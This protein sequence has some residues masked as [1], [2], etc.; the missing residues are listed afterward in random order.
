MPKISAL[1]RITSREQLT[2]NDLIVVND[3]NVTKAISAQILSNRG[4]T[5]YENTSGFEGFNTENDFNWPT[6]EG[7]NYTQTQADSESWMLISLD[8]Q[9][10]HAKDGPYWTDPTPLDHSG[11][12]LFGGANNPIG[13]SSLFDFE[14]DFNSTYPTL[15]SF[16]AY[17]SSANAQLSY[18][19]FSGSTGRI[20]LSGT[21]PGDQLRARFSYNIIPQVS[22]T[23]VETALWYANR[24]TDDKETFSFPLTTSPVF[25][26][27]GSPGQSYLNR[28]EISAWIG[29]SEDVNA[30]TLPAVR[31]NNPV[32]IQPS[33]LLV[34]IL[35]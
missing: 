14:F 8:L 24:N 9:A 33:S 25:Y 11:S 6:G 27:L 10:N 28:I 23:T 18:Q 4:G 34:T 22:N 15:E 30:L 12:G 2:A 21:Q 16:T 26:G 29:Q 13:V 7:L 20:N 31:A 32:I 19:F 5:G 17:T 3:G 1:P 35:R